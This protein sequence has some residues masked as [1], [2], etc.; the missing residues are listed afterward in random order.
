MDRIAELAGRIKKA[1][2]ITAFTGAGV[3]TESDIPDFRSAGGVYEK[4]S[5]E[6]GRQPEELL[7]HG[8]FMEHPD[9]FYDYLRKYLIFPDAKP[10]LG[11]RTLAALERAGKL[12]GVVTQNIDGLHQAA[13]CKKV[14]ELHG[15]IYRNTC[16]RCGRKY[17][18]DYILAASGVPRCESCGGTIK[19]DVVLYGEQ[20]DDSVVMGA[21]EAIERADMLLIMGTSLAVY[22]AAGLIDYF[23]GDDIVL[24]NKSKTPYDGR[25]SLVINDNAGKT[26]KAAAD[27]LGMDV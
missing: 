26:L 21:V 3:S 8:F 1:S 22:P 9:I 24:I 19:P 18:L 5:R 12:V 2:K 16:L 13:G 11:H 15:S 23:R 7:S 4:I 6:Y 14:F 17:G 27:I 25:A 10:N 20:L